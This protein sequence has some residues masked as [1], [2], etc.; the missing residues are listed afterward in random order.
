MPRPIS[1]VERLR[2]YITGVMERADHHAD[3][4]SEVALAL[5]GAIVWRKDVTDIKVFERQGK[6]ANVL[7]VRIGGTRYAFSYNHQA[8][9]IEMRSGSTQGTV[10]HSFNN[11]TNNREIK[12]AFASL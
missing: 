9:T 2:E 1:D 5:V 7:W 4:V 12:E 8:G 3:H 10:L 11:Q 6:M